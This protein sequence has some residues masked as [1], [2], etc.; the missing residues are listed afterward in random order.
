MSKPLIL[1]GEIEMK[2]L[3]CVMVLA[4]F[5]CLPLRAEQA[6]E[7]T[8]DPKYTWDLTDLYPD[9]EAWQEAREEL[10]KMADELMSYNGRLGESAQTLKA[11]LDL[12]AKI[13]KEYRR[14]SS[15]ASMLSDLDIRIGEHRGMKQALAQQ[16]SDISAELSWMTPELLTIGGDRFASFTQEEPALEVYSRVFEKLEKGRPHTLSPEEERI[17][18]LF[19]A[20]SG[21][22][23]NV[24]SILRNTE[25][26][27]ET[28]ILSGN[29]EIKINVSGY[30]KARASNSRM[31]RVLAYNSFFGMLDKYKASLA[32][33][34][35]GTL[36][37]NK[38]AAQA[39]HYDSSLESALKPNEIE[40]AV[41]NNHIAQ[42]NSALPL[43]HR[44]MK[45]K[46]RM[47]NL[48]DLAYYDLY[49]PLAGEVRMD[50]SY[51]KS[52]EVF[53]DSVQVMGQ[54]YVDVLKRAFNERWVDVYPAEGKRS[55]AYMSGSA[56]DVHPYMLLNHQDS[57]DSASTLAHE[58]GHLMHS[59]YSN[60]NQEF[61]N[62]RYTIFV[63]EV[64]SITN[65]W[66]LFKHMLNL[67]ESDEDRLA[68]IGEFLDSVRTTVFR[69]TKFAE[70]EKTI[71]EMMER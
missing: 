3:A 36:K 43:L 68:V 69:Q 19:G 39:R 33:T 4:I 5:A 6:A 31:D 29:E 44:L 63:A 30:V 20:V 28:I 55:G 56:Y 66:L 11:A 47:L 58:A 67:A 71:Y 16:G 10:N 40:L 65:E 27:W 9:N 50:M 61:V 34:L 38:A 35:A 45:L 64:A 14:L 21:T 54:D 22:G 59:Y 26:P 32:E 13:S 1:K 52:V 48:S 37:Y 53:L 23:R 57:Y 15:Y 18:G 25:M 24:G 7:N 2:R 46:A 17:M 8:V 60:T 51:D 12:D 49:M 41:F 42:I 70:F 62:S